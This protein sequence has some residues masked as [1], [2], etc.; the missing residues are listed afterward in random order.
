MQTS[1]HKLVEPAD[2]LELVAEQIGRLRLGAW[3]RAKDEK[4]FFTR[5][6]CSS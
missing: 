6:Q 1:L 5:A 4:A 2:W 3:S